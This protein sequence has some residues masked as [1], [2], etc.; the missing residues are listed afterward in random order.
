MSSQGFFPKFFGLRNSG[1]NNRQQSSDLEE[2]CEPIQEQHPNSSTAP[3]ITTFRTNVGD[4]SMYSPRNPMVTSGY[5]CVSI[6]KTKNQ[7]IAPQPRNLAKIYAAESE[8]LKTF[9]DWTSPV[10]DK[11]TLAKNG[12]IYLHVKDR[13]QCVFCRGVLSDWERGD[14]VANEHKTHCPECPFAFGYETGNIPL[15]NNVAVLERRTVFAPPNALRNVPA[16]P[17]QQRHPMSMTPSAANSAQYNTVVT[18]PVQNRSGIQTSTVNIMPDL[19]SS[20]NVNSQMTIR[21][22]SNL[23]SLHSQLQ[24]NQGNVLPRPIHHNVSDAKRMDDSV[25]MSLPP[26]QFSMASTPHGP[27]INSGPRYPQWADERTRIKSF[28]GWPAQM[29]QT[30]I[31]LAEAGLLYMSK[32]LSIIYILYTYFC[33]QWINFGYVGSFAPKLQY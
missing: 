14:I 7:D 3:H 31:A 32:L 23:A 6:F 2:D 22:N 5:P 12:F 18:V 27:V 8:R 33:G 30:P 9:D 26:G 1:N 11:E 20:V 19:P 28:R 17:Q 16:S 24:G 21:G 25:Q 15:T 10:I 4:H 29:T 13:V